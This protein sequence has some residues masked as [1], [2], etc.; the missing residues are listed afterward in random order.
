MM[1]AYAWKPN[2]TYLPPARQTAWE[3]SAVGDIPVAGRVSATLIIPSPITQGLIGDRL[4]DG[5]RTRQA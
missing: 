4:A 2:L 1:E 3:P 5:G